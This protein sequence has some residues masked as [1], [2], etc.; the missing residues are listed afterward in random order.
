MFPQYAAAIAVL[1]ASGAAWAGPND[2]ILLPTVA[3]EADAPGQLPTLQRPDEL[4]EHWLSG[5]ARQLDV[6]MG[7]A[8]QDLG[9]TLDVSEGRSLTRQDLTDEG[10]VERARQSWVISPRIERVGDQLRVRV[11]AVAPGSS[12]LLTRTLEVE[13]AELELRAMVMLRDVVQAGRPGNGEPANLPSGM[14]ARPDPSTLPARSAGR[15]VLALN[16]AA[17]GGYLGYALHRAADS[18]DPRLTYPLVALGVG[19]GLGASMI[20]ADEWDVG[21]GDA[22]YLSAGAWWPLAAGMLLADGYDVEPATDRYPYGLAGASAGIALAT[23]ALTFRGMGEGGAVMAHSG[24]ALGLVLGGLVQLGYEGR[25]DITPTR[26]MGYG[27]ALGVVSAGAAATQVPVA[28][29]QVLFIDLAAALGG[30][31]AA[32]VGSPLLLVDGDDDE[33]RQTRERL[34]LGG[35]GTGILVGGV[36]GYFMTR[37]SGRADFDAPGFAALPQAG[38]IGMSQ[39]P[40]GEIAPV[41]GLGLSGKW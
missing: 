35:V 40:S 27:A 7:E 22:W 31:T 15:A 25:T 23:T 5:W 24:G 32:A 33:A 11:V 9:L 14:P 20:I 29:S 41:Y 8:A 19:V 39:A 12:V 28:A 30:L 16:T 38:V 1:L 6:V 17:F 13:P 37:P 4:R 18:S 3:P 2:A 26:G 10:L 36:I 21:L 34:W